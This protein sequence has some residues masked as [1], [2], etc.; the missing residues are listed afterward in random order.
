[1]MDRQKGRLMKLSQLFFAL[2][3][4]AL[5]MMFTACS[6]QEEKPTL[7]EP[8]E[9]NED[10]D[11]T[12]QA[13]YEGKI[14]EAR[15]Y[16]IQ[17]GLDPA[18][19]VTQMIEGDERVITWE[20]LCD[21]EQAMILNDFL[22]DAISDISSHNN[23][24]PV[25]R[26]GQDS[27]SNDSARTPAIYYLQAEQA[28]KDGFE[29]V[30]Q[31][32]NLDQG[33]SLITFR[34]NLETR[35]YVYDTKDA[36][37]FYTGISFKYDEDTSI[38]VKQ[39]DANRTAILS[40]NKILIVDSKSLNILKEIIYP[41]EEVLSVD[42]IEFSSDGQTIACANRKGL[43]V[44]DSNFENGKVI[45]ESKIGKDPYG[46][47][48]E[49]PRYPIFSPDSSRIMYRL[50]GYE[51]L[52]GTGIIAP[53]GSDHRYFKADS[54]ETTFIQWYDNNQIYSNGPAYGDFNNPVLHNIQTG[55][56]THLVQDAL[57]NKRIDYFLGNKLYYQ[58]T[59]IN[60]SDN[61]R[62]GYY[63]IISKTW[64]KLMESPKFHQINLSK[65]A[66]DRV[67]NTFVF[68]VDNSPLPGKAAILAGIE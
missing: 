25:W 31:I 40:A 13:Q 49:V 9:I 26:A 7:S 27:G 66:Y 3:V 2:L 15:D 60:E 59:G 23:Y 43:M 11:E 41:K 28:L 36:S 21:D 48:W 50:V 5:I 32:Q 1:M 42:D 10:E 24:A 22:D 29:R 55:E 64:N 44:Y 12:P 37:D 8:V 54:E 57:K 34:N 30:I 46:M 16:L 35:V 63:D 67:N 18:E 45:V 4:I 65:T 51:W 56:N 6:K 68:I 62:F 20:D 17:E 38:R 52:V 53:D 58:E 47:D 19:V 61:W 39:L 14:K 33:R